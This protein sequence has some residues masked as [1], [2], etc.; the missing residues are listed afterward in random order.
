M[1]KTIFF[2]FVE[3]LSFSGQ[4]AAS[5]LLYK[6]FKAEGWN[7]KKIL[8]YPL[9]RGEKNRV[10][11]YADFFQK[12]I[13][14]VLSLKE[15]IIEKD[16]IVHLNLGQSYGSFIR[17]LIPF[18][19]IR[20]KR[21]SCLVISLH[22][23]IFMQWTKNS[24]ICKFFLWY[25][26]PAKMI[27]VLGKSQ[28]DKLFEF[29]I[30]KSAIEIIPN[31]CGFSP[32]EFKKLIHKHKD[33]A[34]IK[35]LHLSL[36]IE[37]KGFPL[38]LEALELLSKR[39]L[40]L[41]LEIVL[42][43]PISFTAY[44]QQFVDEKSKSD[45]IDAKIASINQNEDFR[46]V[47]KK[48]LWGTEKRGEYESSHIFVFPSHFPVETQPLV[49][50]EAMATGCAIMTTKVGEIADTIGKEECMTIAPYGAEALASD[51]LILIRDKERRIALAKAAWQRYKDSYTNE[52]HL[53]SWEKL[54]LTV[55]KQ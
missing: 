54:F 46:I 52:K 49:I 21:T 38:F 42:C 53:A 40:G 23:H 17:F 37:S 12:L 33:S 39:Q 27:T 7:C 14:T 10:K 2:A 16:A 22:G 25:L 24:A 45:W 19:V 55:D 18:I 31:T 43:G 26:N 11:R 50:L 51:M 20:L 48:G 35:L 15:L 36:L 13:K 30:P 28:A 9:N 6:H 8:I 34:V 41:K 44:C 5:E 3:P 29:G 47:W 32:I 1:R 4:S